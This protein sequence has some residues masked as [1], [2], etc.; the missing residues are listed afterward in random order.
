[1][2]PFALEDANTALERLRHGQIVGAAVLSAG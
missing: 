2:T 1:V